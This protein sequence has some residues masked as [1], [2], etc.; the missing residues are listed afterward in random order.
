MNEK[1][2]LGLNMLLSKDSYLLINDVNERAVTH[3]L[4]EYY[5]YI[6][7]EWNV[8]CEYNRNL[9]EVK[10]IDRDIDSLISEILELLNKELERDPKNT[11]YLK[12]A[13]KLILG[14]KISLSAALN[15]KEQLQQHNSLIVRDLAG[16]VYI[17][18]SNARNKRGIVQDRIYKPVLP[19]IIVHHRGTK[20]NLIVIEAKKSTND[21]EEDRLFDILK[22]HILTDPKGK[23]R[24]RF[25]Y[26]LDIPFKNHLK[27]HIGFEIIKHVGFKKVESRS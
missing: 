6:F 4:G 9:G 2:E 3:K 27:N 25:G 14:E 21:I 23:Y 16:M 13:K 10:R 24:Y 11:R 7:P 19:D 1:I 18:I 8:D 26:F 17:A 5:Q 12:S 20:E 22:V 15:L